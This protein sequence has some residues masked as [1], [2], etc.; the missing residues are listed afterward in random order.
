LCGKYGERLRD[1]LKIVEVNWDV[2]LEDIWRWEESMGER[3][4]VWLLSAWAQCWESVLFLFGSVRSTDEWGFRLNSRLCERFVVRL[5]KWF[6]K[7]FDK[8]LVERFDD[9]LTFETGCMSNL[10][11]G[12]QLIQLL[13]DLNM[14]FHHTLIFEVSLF[15]AIYVCNKTLGGTYY[16]ARITTLDLRECIIIKDMKCLTIVNCKCNTW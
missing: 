14:K 8:G 12:R 1:R 4:V 15:W 13:L 2:V 16:D 7:R 6:G 11:K 9:K 3:L 10:G 5:I